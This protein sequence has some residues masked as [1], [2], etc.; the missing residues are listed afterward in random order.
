M[1]PLTIYDIE[2]ILLN[3][4]TE[5]LTQEEWQLLLKHLGSREQVAAYREMLMMSSEFMSTDEMPEL[6]PR[7]NIAAQVKMRMKPQQT[8]K[9]GIGYSILVALGSLPRPL[10]F[11]ICSM[12]LFLFFWFNINVNESVIH[13]NKNANDSL[14]MNFIDTVAV[15]KQDVIEFTKQTQTVLYDVAY[16]SAPNTDDMA[17]MHINGIL[18]YY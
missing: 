2:S 12:L 13:P 17:L 8:Y 7:A 14:T 1:K 18:R 6:T 16:I 15:L 10:K 4:K 5:H 3:K 9:S 11:G